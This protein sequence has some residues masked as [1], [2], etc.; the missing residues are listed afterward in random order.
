MLSARFTAE[1][2]CSAVRCRMG[3]AVWCV[4]AGC[5]GE[6]TGQCGLGKV[7]FLGDGAH[8]GWLRARAA[9]AS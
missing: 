8:Q 7:L 4:V 2:C 3:A 9:P 1:R 5:P 6:G